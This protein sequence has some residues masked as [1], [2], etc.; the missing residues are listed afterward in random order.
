MSAR[1]ADEARVFADVLVL[2]MPVRSLARCCFSTP[3]CTRGMFC[4][5]REAVACSV[6]GRNDWAMK[7]LLII[8]NSASTEGSHSGT[9]SP[10]IWQG[11]SCRL[12]FSRVSDMPL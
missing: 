2:D 1:I 4:S 8:P 3:A 9:D 5:V 10:L 12:I 11:W 6:S 7:M